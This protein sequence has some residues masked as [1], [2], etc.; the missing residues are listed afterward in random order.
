[1]SRVAN[2]ENSFYAKPEIVNEGSSLHEEMSAEEL[3]RLFDFDDDEPMLAETQ[4]YCYRVV[5]ETLRR[6]G[7]THAYTEDGTL[8][9]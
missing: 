4:A 8:L 6:L 7:I 1:M 3:D 5:V 9:L 2:D